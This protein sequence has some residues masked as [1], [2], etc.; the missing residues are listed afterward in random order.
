LGKEIDTENSVR[1]LKEFEQ[2]VPRIVSDVIIEDLR[3]KDDR[4]K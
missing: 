2:H 3:D 1:Q 4:E